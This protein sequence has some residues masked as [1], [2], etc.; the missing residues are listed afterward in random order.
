MV[1]K[2]EYDNA[3]KVLER[4]KQIYKIMKKLYLIDKKGNDELLKIEG[5]T[6]VE[7]FKK[8]N[9]EIFN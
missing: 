5:L 4:A 6:R 2:L 8:Y 1:H 9:V 7:F 3:K